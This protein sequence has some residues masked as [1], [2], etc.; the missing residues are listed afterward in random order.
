MIITI[1]NSKDKE[2][3]KIRKA[4]DTLALRVLNRIQGKNGWWAKAEEDCGNYD[5]YHYV[6]GEWIN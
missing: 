4:T 1:Y 5:I 2:Q 6:D 3:R